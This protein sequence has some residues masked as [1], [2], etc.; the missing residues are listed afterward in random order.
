[1]MVKQF[2]AEMPLTARVGMAIILINLFVVLFAP[3][4]APYSETQLVTDVWAPP[5]SENWL[6]GDQLGRDMLTRI[7]YGART[8]ITIAFIATML[9][10]V[11]GIIAGFA[12]AIM[13]GV[14]DM[15]LSRLVE[16]LM[17]IPTLILALVI[18]S[19]LGTDIIVLI[20]VI[21]ALDSTR[22]FR[23]S[24]AIA[25]D[26]AVMEYVEAARLRGEG[27]WWVM[28]R[29]VLPNAVMPLVAEF[30]LRFAFAFLFIAS[31]SFLGLGIQPPLADWGGMVR[32]NATAII[33]GIPAPLYPAAA[34][35]VL[36][37]GVNLLVD[38]VLARSNR[39]A[40]AEFEG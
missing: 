2:F 14:V 7:I 24:R 36:A 40:A 25:M 30:G 26:I 28:T 21:A 23:L 38:Y 9:S 34:I 27:L 6:G 39:S 31:L 13:G 11:L 12:A 5:S 8:T 3:L 4:I 22:V 29:E 35:A 33:Y 32:E 18:I 10:F 37:I 1:M 15:V 16:A 19:V 20:G 17:A